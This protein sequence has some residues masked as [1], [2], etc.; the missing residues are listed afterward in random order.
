MDTCPPPAKPPQQPTRA[1]NASPP[2]TRALDSDFNPREESGE[3][4]PGD[5]DRIPDSKFVATEILAD[6]LCRGAGVTVRVSLNFA[7]PSMARQALNMLARGPWAGALIAMEPSRHGRPHLFGILVVSSPY[8]VAQV[9]SVI[10]TLQCGPDQRRIDELPRH[11]RTAYAPNLRRV[12]R[13]A[14]KPWPPQFGERSSADVVVTGVLDAPW[15]R[16]QERRPA[17]APCG[18]RA[19]EAHMVPPLDPSP[20]ATAAPGTVEPLPMGREGDGRK[21][22]AP[23]CVACG[24]AIK[25]WRRSDAKHCSNTCRVV[26]HRRRRKLG[27][28]GTQPPVPTDASRSSKTSTE[29]S[30]L[31][32]DSNRRKLA[33][34]QRISGCVPNVLKRGIKMSVKHSR[35]LPDVAIKTGAGRP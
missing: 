11:S 20:A 16:A 10:A 9:S 17:T 22:G 7:D 28:Q 21:R 31:H 6:P 1:C 12:L 34:I 19:R 18:V 35:A 30:D 5:K 29:P 24:G 8:P 4:I 15:R 25:K 2:Y 27:A 26:A 32:G 33:S 13:Y 3:G 14:L 23:A